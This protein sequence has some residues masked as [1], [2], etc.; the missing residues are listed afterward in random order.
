M[1]KFYWIVVEPF[2]F[3]RKSRFVSSEWRLWR[4]NDNL[5]FLVILTHILYRVSHLW[6][7]P[8]N[9]LQIA[10][11]DRYSDF[12]AIFEMSCLFTTK[13]TQKNNTNCPDKGLNYS[14]SKQAK[15]LLAWIL[16]GDKWNGCSSLISIDIVNIRSFLEFLFCL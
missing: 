6:Q 4:W 12:K 3:K 1:L 16:F 8:G 10:N 7:F 2:L 13:N 9:W 15:K 14:F 5:N 11:Y